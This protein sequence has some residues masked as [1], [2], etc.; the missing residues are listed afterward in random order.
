MTIIHTHIY[1]TDP[2]HKILIKTSATNSI[3]Y[4]ITHLQTNASV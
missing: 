3:T 1:I 4:C 2:K